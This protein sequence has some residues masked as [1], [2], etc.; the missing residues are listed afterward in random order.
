[1]LL[2]YITGRCC[3]LLQTDI[4][5]YMQV[6][7]II[8]CR[9]CILQTGIV[10]YR[11]LLFI[12]SKWCLLQTV[13]V[14]YRQVYITSYWWMRVQPSCVFSLSVYTVYVSSLSL[15][16]ILTSRWY[17]W[18]LLFPVAKQHIIFRAEESLHILFSKKEQKKDQRM[19]VWIFSCVFLSF[20][21][22]ITNNPFVCFI[23]WYA[24]SW[25]LTGK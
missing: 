20:Q 21:C 1:M 17:S 6:L 19:Q 15:V 25:S 18:I 11:Q 5:Y 14:Y 22:L 16:S 9:C 8:K 10:Y 13:I 7:F 24:I 3:L 12:T 4:L 23:C 2:L